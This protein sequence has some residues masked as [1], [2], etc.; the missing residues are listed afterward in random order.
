[1]PSRACRPRR[2]LFKNVHHVAAAQQ[3]IGA[4][5]AGGPAPITATR[6]ETGVGSTRSFRK[7]S[8]IVCPQWS[9]A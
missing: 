4:V 6:F 2:V 3:V 7:S 1:M 8:P 9:A 5:D